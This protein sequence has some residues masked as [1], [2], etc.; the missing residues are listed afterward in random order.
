MTVAISGLAIIAVLT[1]SSLIFWRSGRR[2]KTGVA[3]SLRVLLVLAA[4]VILWR[5]ETVSQVKPQEPSEVVVLVDRSGSMQ[6]RDAA[7]A[8]GV[9]SRTDVADQ[10]VSNANWNQLE[11][12]FVR[13]VESFGDSVGGGTDLASAIRE[14][15]A[16]HDRAAAIIVA[17]DGDWQGNQ[18]PIEVVAGLSLLAKTSPSVFSIPL[19]NADRL[20][21]FELVQANVP[22]FGVVDQPVRIQFSLANWFDQLRDVT[23]ELRI[24]G[25]V[26]EEQ[27]F[28]LASGERTDGDFSWQSDKPGDFEVEVI[29]QP[30]PSESIPTNN[31]ARRK[32]QIRNETL[33][34]LVIESTPRWEYRYL[35]NALI[36]DP[37]I[38]VSCYLL[39][40]ELEGVG[41]GGT[42]YV[43]TLPDRMADWAAYDVIFLGDVGVGTTQVDPA[44]VDP[45]HSS[46]SGLTNE[47][48]SL[49]AGL[50]RQQAVGLVLMPGRLGHQRQLLA[51]ELAELFP[52]VTDPNQPYGIGGPVEGTLSLTQLGRQSLLTELVDDDQS[53]WAIWESLPGFYWH[54]A[55]ERAK[56]GSEVLA[57]HGSSSNR[58]GRLP[59][60]VTRPAGAGKVLFMGTDAAW[61]WRRG[62]EDLYHYRFWGQVIRWMAYQRNM[63]VGQSMRLSYRPEKIRQGDVVS[64]RASVMTSSGAPEQSPEVTLQVRSPGGR[65]ETLSLARQD[66]QWG[67]YVG[68][69]RLDEPGEHVLVLSHPSE[70]TKLTTR[71]MVQGR[72]LEQVG[73]PARPDV[74]REMAR[75]G[76]GKAFEPG[77]VESLVARLGQLPVDPS[78][79]IRTQWWSHPAVM[80]TM[81]VGLSLFW[82]A[83]KWSGAL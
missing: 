3:E 14:A 55:V 39:H 78:N 76:G 28:S 59:L 40:P 35:R 53:N 66:L 64:L 6:T 44:Q 51:T 49:I 25:R 61:R 24:D 83:R 7:S 56:A 74:M 79:T 10:F 17:S 60:L 21:D 31:Q 65:T 34:V 41:G 5:P 72:A 11:P 16:R 68:E 12:R 32:L 23:V 62:V 73:A 8:S 38:D 67:V 80:F 4:V 54:A 1:A 2:W 33:R 43:S 42:D 29:I 82:I 47:Q 75:V 45:A 36:R 30:D 37:G 18:S 63:S 52:V 9:Q 70:P 46:R 15:A 71:V 58:Y 13:I 81:M 48:C 19:G 22:T 77:Q 57:V 26:V 27:S 69:A 20:P 50:V